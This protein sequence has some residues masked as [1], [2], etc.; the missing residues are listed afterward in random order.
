MKKKNFSSTKLKQLTFNIEVKKYK[1][2][3]KAREALYKR[4]QQTNADLASNLELRQRINEEFVFMRAD[5]LELEAEQLRRLTDEIQRNRALRE[6][7]N[8][9][10]AELKKIDEKSWAKDPSQPIPVTQI[11]KSKP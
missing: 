3:D 4:L 7:Q 9:L 5:H 2:D 6:R 11:S 8:Q 10:Q 1:K